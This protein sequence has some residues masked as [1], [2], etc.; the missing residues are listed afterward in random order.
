[1]TGTTL[2]LPLT[3]LG[4]LLLAPGAA[5]GTAAPPPQGATRLLAFGEPAVVETAILRAT[6]IVLH[7]DERLRSVTQPD[8]ER[9]QVDFS[10]YGP[11]GAASP[12]VTVTP[13][14]CGVTTN[15]LLLTTKRIYPILLRSRPCDLTAASLD[16]QL[17]FDALVRFRYPEEEL[18]R[19]FAQ[20]PAP[21]AAEPVRLAAPLERLLAEAGRF[22]WRGRNGYRGPRPRLVTSDGAS[23]YLVFPSGSF[24]GQDLPLFFLLNERGERELANFD[25]E[26]TTLVVRTTFDRAVL[27]AGGKS[28]RRQPHLLIRRGSSLPRPIWRRHP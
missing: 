9:W 12:V 25:V 28:G 3:L 21:P 15:L 26:G 14:D 22:T 18:T 2:A 24:R 20:P 4:P 17:P 23:T 11:E 10:E 27:V 7:P 16:P 19:D 1:M 5:R 13:A 8:S 6:G